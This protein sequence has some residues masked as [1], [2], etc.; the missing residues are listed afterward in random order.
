[1]ANQSQYDVLLKPTS[2]SQYQKEKSCERSCMG[3]SNHKRGKIGDRNAYPGCWIQCTHEVAA[4]LHE[5]ALLQTASDPPLFYPLGTLSH[6]SWRPCGHATKS[7]D[8]ISLVVAFGDGQV[9]KGGSDIVGKASNTLF[10]RRQGCPFPY[11]VQSEVSIRVSLR[12]FVPDNRRGNCCS[13][14]CSLL[15]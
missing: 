7:I 10:Y 5:A 2:N 1:M 3:K 6:V 4:Y 14:D 12:F 8:R 15:R 11:P 9:G 13:C